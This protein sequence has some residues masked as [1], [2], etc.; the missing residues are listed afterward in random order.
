MLAV[1]HT[2]RVVPQIFAGVR[3]V[4]LVPQPEQEKPEVEVDGVVAVD[5]AVV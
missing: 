3:P 5:V 2:Y 1:K 4:E